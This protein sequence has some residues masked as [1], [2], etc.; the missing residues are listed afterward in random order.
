[1]PSV[2]ERLREV[3]SRAAA[4]ARRAVGRVATRTALEP[5][6]VPPRTHLPPRAPARWP[7]A[8]SIALAIAL[9]VGAAAALWAARLLD[10]TDAV[11]TTGG[12]TV[13]S[14]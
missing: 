12:L 4:V 13:T 10:G 14:K 5:T 6:A 9:V 11:A 3:S 2:G 8:R 1:M 7:R